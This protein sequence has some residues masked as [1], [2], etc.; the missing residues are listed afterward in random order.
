[1]EEIQNSKKMP[2]IQKK[3]LCIF[4]ICSQPL[5]NFGRGIQKIGKE[6]AQNIDK[7]H[8]CIS[9][10]VLIHFNTKKKKIHFY[11]GEHEIQ[12]QKSKLF[13]QPR[14]V[15]QRR[16]TTMESVVQLSIGGPARELIVQQ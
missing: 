8:D 13:Y 12:S 4:P 11:A 10:S 5:Q 6:I 3:R 14:S 7:K 9:P 1:M 2:K 15:A 16:E